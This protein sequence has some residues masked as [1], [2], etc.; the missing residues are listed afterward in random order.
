MIGSSSQG[1]HFGVRR[2]VAV[3]LSTVFS[4][5]N[6]LAVENNHAAHGH[7]IVLAGPNG[8]VER[9]FHEVIIGARV[10]GEHPTIHAGWSA[11]LRTPWAEPAP[12]GL[13]TYVEPFELSTEQ[14]LLA[15]AALRRNEEG[16]AA[17][18]AWLSAYDVADTS[19][20]TLR[21]LPYVFDA[22]AGERDD[23]CGPGFANLGKVKRLQ[24]LL[25]QGVLRESLGALR[26]TGVATDQ[27]L[28][29][30]GLA[31]NH[32][33]EGTGAIRAFGDVDLFVPA[34]QVSR[35]ASAIQEQGFHAVFPSTSLERWFRRD[36]AVGVMPYRHSIDF[37]NGTNGRLDLHWQIIRR[38]SA[39]VSASFLEASEKTMVAGL[40]ARVP[41]REDTLVLAIVKGFGDRNEGIRWMAD[42]D[43][44]W[45]TATT[46]LNWQRIVSTAAL[47]EHSQTVLLGF[48]TFCT[49]SSLD[50]GE[51]PWGQLRENAAGEQQRRGSGADVD[52]K[53]AQSRLSRWASHVPAFAV[54]PLR[55][56][57][58]RRRVDQLRTVMG[59]K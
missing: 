48:T 9:Q 50:A 46:P 41:C 16:A 18:R 17:A 42:V 59:R 35:W 49:Y 39:A 3:N 20:T 31:I 15:T 11:I 55:E 44:L 37:F 33:L 10:H 36:G 32:Y 25:T 24:W 22:H 30:K 27:V 45:R 51:V 38:N 56:L 23:L 19:I 12:E 40:E 13:K 1:H 21:F 4:H 53:T 58:H 54:A 29:L 6:D 5:A 34:A 26:A 8:G 47:A 43:L 52:D 57:R 7:I 28:L 14:Q 2:R